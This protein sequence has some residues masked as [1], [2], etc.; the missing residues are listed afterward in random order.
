LFLYNPPK[1]QLH[2][3]M[4]WRHTQLVPSTAD[5]HLYDNKASQPRRS[6]PKL[7]LWW[8]LQLSWDHMC[9]HFS[10]RDSVNGWAYWTFDTFDV[11][12]VN[13]I[14]GPSVFFHFACF[15][16]CKQMRKKLRLH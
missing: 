2:T 8:K 13:I 4:P 6:Q 5:I 15:R 12:G 3:L 7:S 9:S 16:N 10:I 14:C 1:C 11:C